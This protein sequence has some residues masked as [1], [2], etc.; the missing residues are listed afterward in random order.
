[1]ALFAD[2]PAP[3]IDDLVAQDSGL[4]DV[5]Q[6]AG[7]NVYTKLRLAQ[8]EIATELE[9]WLIKPRPVPEVIWGPP[10]LRG[11][12]CRDP[13][14]EAM[15][16]HACA[17]VGLS[18]RLFQPTGRSLSGEMAGV[19]IAVARRQRKLHC[20]RHGA[21]AVIRCTGRSR[22]FSLS[23]RGRRAA[24]CFTRACPG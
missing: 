1:M 6:T 14:S 10:P 16:D 4:L 22:R 13:A 23:C 12:D 5:A 7:I 19:R 21:G 17:G 15:G 2:G 18:R 24:V 20:E 11:P 9:L 8:E 3:T